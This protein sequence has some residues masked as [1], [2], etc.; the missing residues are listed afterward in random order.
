MDARTF[1]RLILP[2]YGRM[3]N[4]AFRMSD[5]DKD[6]AGDVVQECIAYMWERRESLYTSFPVSLCLTAVRNRCISR[7]R[8]SAQFSSLEEA[9]DVPDPGECD[10][11]TDRV[12]VSLRLLPDRQREVMLMSMRGFSPAE[13]AAETTLSPDNVRQLLSRG[14]RRLKEILSEL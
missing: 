6:F 10:S 7:L 9:A 5:G 3:Y 11:D 12:H 14:R 4:L 8:A 13:I 1:K 2:C